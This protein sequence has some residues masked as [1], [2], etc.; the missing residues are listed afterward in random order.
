VKYVIESEGK[1][2]QYCHCSRCRKRSGSAFTSS[3][4]VPADSFRFIQGA[5]LIETYRPANDRFVTRFCRVC[6]SRVPGVFSDGGQ[7]VAGIPMGAL[8]DDPARAPERHA[9]VGSKAPWH[10]IS[11]QLPRYEGLPPDFL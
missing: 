2:A 10:T 1:R 8:D 4:F 6:G 3:L 5:E 7:E 11:D 9:F